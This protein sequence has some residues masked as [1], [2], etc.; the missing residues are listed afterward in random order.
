VFRWVVQAERRKLLR[1]LPR[2][3]VF[4]QCRSDLVR[5]LCCGHH[6]GSRLFGVQLKQHMLHQRVRLPF[7]LQ[8][9]LV[10]RERGQDAI[11]LVPGFEQQLRHLWWLLLLK[12]CGLS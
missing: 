12:T 5:N 10:Q 4:F 6:V 1:E 7:S 3:H 9:V 8:A 2:G 11:G